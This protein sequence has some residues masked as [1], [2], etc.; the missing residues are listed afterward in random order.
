MSGWS[1]VRVALV[2]LLVLVIVVVL[3]HAGHD[4][5]YDHEHDPLMQLTKH[6][7]AIL[8]D[9]AIDLAW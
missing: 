3:T 4:Q 2:L 7:A 6:W 9:Y 8:D 5:D 1:E